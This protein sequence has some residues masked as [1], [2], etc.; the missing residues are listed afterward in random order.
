MSKSNTTI[1]N[2]ETFILAGIPGLDSSLFWVSIPFFTMYIISLL[3]NLILVYIIKTEP[4]LHTP[5]YYLLSLLA[6]NDLMIPTTVIPKMLGIYWFNSREIHFTACLMQ[7]YFI[8]SFSGFESGIISVM[9]IDR[10]IA[11]CHP[12]RYATILTNSRIAKIVMVVALRALGIL[13][14][15]PFLLKRLSYCKTNVIP[16]SY[17]EFMSIA[18]ISCSNLFITSAYGL[19]VVTLIVGLDVI[20]ITISYVMILRTIFNLPSTGKKLK[21]FSTCGSHVCVILLFYSPALSSFLM[22][23]FAKNAPK[24]VQPIMANV[25]LFCPPMLNPFV[26]GVRTK[27]V[28]QRILN[29]M[30]W[31]KKI[32]HP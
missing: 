22:L 28:R 24:Y 2:P 3:G 14:P 25:Y 21:A 18:K 19:T 29:V 10:Y 6:L 1:T 27:Q 7:M 5:M 16:H 11:I 17:C 13:M 32:Q 15:H 20:L 30:K 26:Y 23:R 31:K 8:H 9:A 4:S 12:L